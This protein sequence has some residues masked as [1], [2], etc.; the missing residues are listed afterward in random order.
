VAKTG[1][2]FDA[3]RA[4]I[5]DPSGYIRENIINLAQDFIGDQLEEV[6]CEASKK[7]TVCLQVPVCRLSRFVPPCL[8]QLGIKNI[9]D[10]KAKI[11]FG[12]G[13]WH[14]YFGKRLWETRGYGLLVA[15]VV[16]ATSAAAIQELMNELRAQYASI[17]NML[18]Q[19]ARDAVR[20]KGAA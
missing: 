15:S 3:A 17:I 8:Q 13:D 12:G 6:S 11:N 10:N 16:P 19:A 18:E 4:A 9:C 1:E 5:S 14:P 2:V 20:Q 7:Q